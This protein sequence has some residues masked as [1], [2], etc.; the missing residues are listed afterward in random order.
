MWEDQAG[1]DLSGIP[2]NSAEAKVLKEILERLEEGVAG[3]LLQ[4]MSREVL[5][6]RISLR[7]AVLGGGYSD[8]F[9]AGMKKFFCWFDQLTPDQIEQLQ[10][11]GEDHIVSLERE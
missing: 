3:P 6:G 5:S 10:K 11:E 9:E 2:Q 7:E 8:V 1:V 4:E